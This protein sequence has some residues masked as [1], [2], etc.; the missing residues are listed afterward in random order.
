MFVRF[1]FTERNDRSNVSIIWKNSYTQAA[2][3]CQQFIDFE[4]IS[5]S[6]LMNFGG[7]VSKPTDF[8]TSISFKIFFNFW[9]LYL[10]EI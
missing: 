10:L 6:N 8:L 7:I 9:R 1:F 3:Y 4:I 2:I 5:A